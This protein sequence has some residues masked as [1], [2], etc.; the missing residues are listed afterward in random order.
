M[1]KWIDFSLG[2]ICEAFV[3]TQKKS[4]CNEI[5]RLMDDM[6][7]QPEM[8]TGMENSPVQFIL[9]LSLSLSL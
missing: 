5:Y 7:G 8:V 6:A 2:V 4:Y 9:S 1:N 3:D